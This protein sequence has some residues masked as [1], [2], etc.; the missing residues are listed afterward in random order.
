[1]I[2]D[3]KK[4]TVSVGPRDYEYQRYRPDCAAVIEKQWG[5]REREAHWRTG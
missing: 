1:M 4:L 3:L 5:V 2:L